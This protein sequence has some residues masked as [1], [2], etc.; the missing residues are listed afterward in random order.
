MITRLKSKKNILCQGK[1]I[2]V[3]DSEQ[4][5]LYGILMVAYFAKNVW[6]KEQGKV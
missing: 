5:N 2:K 6:A 1:L 4:L 3:E